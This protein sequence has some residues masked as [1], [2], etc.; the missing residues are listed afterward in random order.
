MLSWDVRQSGLAVLH[1][2]CHWPLL[3]G[4]VQADNVILAC[5]GDDAKR[6]PA[7]SD[8]SE[9]ARKRAKPTPP[10]EAAEAPAPAPAA[11]AAAAAAATKPPKHA[12]IDYDP[13]T[14]PREQAG[15]KAAGQ[16]GKQ[17][18]RRDARSGGARDGRTRGDRGRGAGE[19]APES[20]SRR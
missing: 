1:Q 7:H 10:A 5:R 17:D 19:R 16:D 14:V 13:S 2:V 11:P 8:K 4:H 12:P 18:E 20:R 6:S 3:A 9:S 15:T